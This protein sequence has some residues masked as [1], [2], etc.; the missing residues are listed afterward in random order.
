M[1]MSGIGLAATLALW[2][3][4]LPADEVVEVASGKANAKAGL[5]S[6]GSPASL[7]WPMPSTPA[8]SIAAPPVPLSVLPFATMGFAVPITVAAPQKLQVGE[9]NELVVAV[10]ANAGVNEISF[11]VQFEPDVLQVRAG[12]EGSWAEGAGV[13]ARFAAEVSG[14]GRPRTD[15]QRRV[16]PADRRGRRHRGHRAIPGRWPGHNVDCDHRRRGQGLGG[17]VDSL[18][19]LGIAANDG[20]RRATAAAR[21]VAPA[22]RRRRGTAHRDH[23]RRRLRANA[24]QRGPP[25]RC[26]QFDVKGRRFRR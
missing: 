26:R 20:G 17:E 10:G 7:V 1:A 2:L 9:M 3:W 16:G 19:R 8:I 14:D 22:R 25:V 15:S 13:N 4:W 21:G 6:T 23:R 12:T 5:Q 24:I 11:T 18:C